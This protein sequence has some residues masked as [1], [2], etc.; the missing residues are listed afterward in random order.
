MC[1]QP[2]EKELSDLRRRG[3]CVR[4]RAVMVG[5]VVWTSVVEDFETV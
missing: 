2:G 3:S 1:E 4:R 5:A